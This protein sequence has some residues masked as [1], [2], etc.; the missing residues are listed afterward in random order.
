MP[1]VAESGSGAFACP[2]RTSAG[3]GEL[4][5]AMPQDLL[6]Q[7][8]SE[9]LKICAENEG[10]FQGPG[11]LRQLDESR[12]W[13]E[14]TEEATGV[15]TNIGTQPQ[16]DIRDEGTHNKCGMVDEPLKP[17]DKKTHIRNSK[18]LSLE[19]GQ[20]TDGQGGETRKTEWGGASMDWSKDGAEKF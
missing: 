16:A 3:V 13:M 14:Q 9:R 7:L 15:T 2:H 8:G 20:A 19:N 1:V 10:R 12:R 11:R 5:E 18:E 17:Y 4:G 6:E